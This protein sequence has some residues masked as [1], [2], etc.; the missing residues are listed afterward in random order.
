MKILIGITHPKHV[1]MFK[2]FIKKMKER[3]HVILCVVVE[4][5]F[6]RFLMRYYSIDAVYISANKGSLTKK[7]LGLPSLIIKTLRIAIKFKPDIL[8]GQAFPHFATT[9][10]IIRKPFIILE[11]TEVAKYLHKFV[12]PLSDTVFT[13]SYFRRK[14][15]IKEI[16]LKCNYEMLYLH[17]LYFEPNSEVLS[18]FNI[19]PNEKFTIIRF[20]SW[21][22]YHDFGLSG[23]TLENK[24]LAVEKF[25][26]FGKVFISSEIELPSQLKKYE[27]KIPP[28]MMHDLLYYASLFYGESATMAAESA[29]LGTPAIYIDD[30]GR[31]YTDELEKEFKL[32]YNFSSSSENQELSILKGI[33]LLEDN[34]TK[35]IWCDRRNDM[36]KEK[37]EMNSFLVWFIENYPE[38]HKIMKENPEYQERFR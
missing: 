25:L 27:T 12:L 9:S 31:G 38:S 26:E 14:L 1:H 24:I 13:T 5:D 2:H 35:S 7:I 36:L 21:Q 8:I 11:D 29:V 28:E 18:Y 16:K 6:V 4:K 19:L 17:P 15:G 23:I 32:M 33:E 20:V 30:N 34:N 37:I 10:F 22:A 3:G